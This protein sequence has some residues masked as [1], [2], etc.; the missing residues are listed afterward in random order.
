MLLF[1]LHSFFLD[2]PSPE[3]LEHMLQKDAGEPSLVKKL[4]GNRTCYG[5][6]KHKKTTAVFNLQNSQQFTDTQSRNIQYL[7]PN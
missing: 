7:S 6:I 3:N 2:L 1:E 4:V 5:W